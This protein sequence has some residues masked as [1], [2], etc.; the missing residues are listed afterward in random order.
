MRTELTF[1]WKWDT[2]WPCTLSGSSEAMFSIKFGL[3][4]LPSWKSLCTYP[5]GQT[6]PAFT[7]SPLPYCNTYAHSHFVSYFCWLPWSVVLLI[8]SGN[9]AQVLFQHTLIFKLLS[10]EINSWVLALIKVRI[11]VG[12]RQCPAVLSLYQ[13]CSCGVLGHLLHKS[14]TRY[15]NI[16]SEFHPKVTFLQVT[17]VKSV[18][19]TVPCPWLPYLSHCHMQ[20]AITDWFLFTLTCWSLEFIKTYPIIFLIAWNSIVLVEK[21]L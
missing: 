19:E 17:C 10:F 16:I 20:M 1:P 6:K 14:L 7:N 8:S 18:A 11:Q 9:T 4:I 2:A 21:H 15:E 12:Y 5:P 13:F 3:F